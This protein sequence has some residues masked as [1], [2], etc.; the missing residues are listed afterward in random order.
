MF[1]TTLVALLESQPSL[2]TKF[3]GLSLNFKHYIYIL[4]KGKLP[5]LETDKKFLRREFIAV[6]L[7]S[8]FPG[9]PEICS[10]MPLQP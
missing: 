7:S 8:Q 5:H 2:V 1:I 6:D 3:Y 10:Q 9:S 4:C